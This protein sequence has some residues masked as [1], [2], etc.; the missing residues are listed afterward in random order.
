[1]SVPICMPSPKRTWAVCAGVSWLTAP[2]RCR[3]SRHPSSDHP[4]PPTCAVSGLHAVCVWGG[5]CLLP[6]CTDLRCRFQWLVFPQVVLQVYCCM[7][8][9]HA[10]LYGCTT[11]VLLYGCTVR[12]GVPL[13]VC[14]AYMCNGV[15]HLCTAYMGALLCV[16]P[17]W[18]HSVMCTAYTVVLPT[19]VHCY[20]YCLHGCTPRVLGQATA[21]AHLMLSSAGHFDW[22]PVLRICV[23]V[24]VWCVRA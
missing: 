1:M 18:V 19:C 23:C 24:C 5:A 3:P 4:Q 10:L 13:H 16:L 15:L 12:L 6:A 22:H 2:S 20:V 17:T 11:H 21:G 7:V 14:T 8:V 9:L